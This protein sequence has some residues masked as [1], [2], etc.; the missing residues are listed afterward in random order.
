MSDVITTTPNVNINADGSSGRSLTDGE[1]TAVIA[2]GCLAA[3]IFL[4]IATIVVFKACRRRSL[5]DDPDPYITPVASEE[6]K[7]QASN[8]RFDEPIDTTMDHS[9]RTGQH[10]SQ[11]NTYTNAGYN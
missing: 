2:G 10:L 5:A 3:G 8:E 11:P 1:R 4:T 6:L 9:F 7:V